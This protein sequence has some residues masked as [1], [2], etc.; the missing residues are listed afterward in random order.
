MFL[1]FTLG[2]MSEMILKGSRVL[3]EKIIKAGYQFTF[4]DLE[5]VLVNL[6]S[7]KLYEN[8]ALSSKTSG[9]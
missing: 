9:L 5:E 3:S 8:L 6:L 4:F 2:K 7:K 1:K